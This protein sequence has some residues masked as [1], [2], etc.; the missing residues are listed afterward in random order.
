LLSKV[1]ID[2]YMGGKNKKIG[3]VRTK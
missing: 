3:Y 2:W 1:I